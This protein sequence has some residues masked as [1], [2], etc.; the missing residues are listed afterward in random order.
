[1]KA[2]NKDTPDRI[3]ATGK[4]LK[5]NKNVTIKKIITISIF[6]L[7]LKILLTAWRSIKKENIYIDVFSINTMGKPPGSLELSSITH[8]LIIIDELSYM[9]NKQKGTINMIKPIWSIKSRYP[10]SNLLENMSI[11]T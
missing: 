1:M 2:N 5:R 11:R 7:L 3:K 6:Y 4:P 9:T 8:D 10:I